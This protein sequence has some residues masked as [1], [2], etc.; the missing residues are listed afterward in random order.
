MTRT[1]AQLLS[2]VTFIVLASCGSD[3]RA[4]SQADA[5]LPRIQLASDAFKSGQSIPTQYTC[6][7]ANQTPPLHWADPPLNTKSLALAVEDPDA[8]FATFRHWGVYDIPASARSLGGE[9]HVGTEVNNDNGAKGYTGPCP[10]R[11]MHHYHFKLFA[12]N[13]EK[14]NLQANATV[15]D[16]ENVARQHAIAEGELIGTYE[17]K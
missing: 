8:P 3:D 13:V 16:L 11:G 6:N 5:R 15:K 1:S 7:G 10:P 14:L 17:H 9:Q 12:L 4:S 2:V